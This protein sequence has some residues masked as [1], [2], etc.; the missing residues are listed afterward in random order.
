VQEYGG[1]INYMNKQTGFTLIEILIAITIFAIGMLAVALMQSSAIKGNYSSS[2]MTEAVT[3]AQDRLELLMARECTDVLIDPDLI[4]TNGNGTNQDP[5]D[6]GIDDGGGNFGLDDTGANADGLAAG[7][8]H[9]GKFDVS[10]NIATD[11]PQNSS[12]IIKVIVDWQEKG[13]ARSVT[14]DSIKSIE[15]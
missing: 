6:N 8:G 7:Q 3:L 12:R 1:K 11:E 4:D 2:S 15:P 14:V 5:D 9:S 13:V 10:W